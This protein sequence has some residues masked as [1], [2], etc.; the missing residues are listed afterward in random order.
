[1]KSKQFLNKTYFFSIFFP[2]TT[3]KVILNWFTIQFSF[4]FLHKLQ[5]LNKTEIEIENA[6]EKCKWNANL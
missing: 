3:K 2:E 5:N 4:F 1:M 6:Q